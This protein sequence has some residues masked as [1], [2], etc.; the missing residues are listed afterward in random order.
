M[1]KILCYIIAIALIII[2]LAS[3]NSSIISQ[4]STPNISETQRSEIQVSETEQIVSLTT[5]PTTASETQTTVTTTKESTMKPTEKETKL[6]TIATTK[7]LKYKVIGTVTREYVEKK[8]KNYDKQHYF[9]YD[10]E[11]DF[12]LGF[13]YNNAQ[14][15]KKYGED[16][17]ILT[18]GGNVSSSY[19]GAGFYAKKGKIVQGGACCYIVRHGANPG[20]GDGW[21]FK[22]SFLAQEGWRV[23][24]FYF[25]PIYTADV[26]ESWDMFGVDGYFAIEVLE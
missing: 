24:D 20:T 15:K 3:C 14:L 4:P 1:K 17:D 16:F 7:E 21:T 8:M 9:F 19:A 2:T 5:T 23:D 12:V 18:A 11:M 25:D 6:S 10:H 26:R 22:I 13:A